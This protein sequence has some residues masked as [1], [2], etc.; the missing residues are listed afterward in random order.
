MIP[1]EELGEKDPEWSPSDEKCRNWLS[2]ESFPTVPVG[3][4]LLAHTIGQ[5]QL[6]SKTRRHN[7][8]EKPLLSGRLPHDNLAFPLTSHLGA[9]TTRRIF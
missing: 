2:P 4:H 6:K 8:P 9:K 1:A 3:M 5:T 7:S